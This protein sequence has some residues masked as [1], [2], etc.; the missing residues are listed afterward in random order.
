MLCAA[1]LLC[2]I[3]GYSPFW[4]QGLPLGWWRQ[5]GSHCLLS[6]FL[7]QL[8]P[9]LSAKDTYG[10]YSPAEQKGLQSGSREETLPNHLPFCLPASI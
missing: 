1:G 6:P 7:Q 3:G 5:G 9:L 2:V 10:L 4:N 8:A